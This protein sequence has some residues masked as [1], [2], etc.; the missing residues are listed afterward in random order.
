MFP[1][2][3]SALPLPPRPSLERYRKLAKDL[4]KACKEAGERD[5]ES[6]G[7]DPHPARSEEWAGQWAGQWAEDWID[8]LVRL[9][10]IALEPHLPVRVEQWIDEVAEFAQW[11]LKGD[12][13][14]GRACALTD[15][16]FV[17]ARSHGFESWPKFVHGVEALAHDGVSQ[18]SRFEAAADAIVAGDM[19]TLQRLLKDE[20]GLI[21]ARSMREHGASLLHYVAANG[22]E[23]YRQKTP[24]NIVEITELLLA[25]GADIEATAEVYAGSCKTLGLAATSGHPERGGDGGSAANAAAA[26]REDR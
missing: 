17:I 2:P 16:Q 7:A 1:N 25:A 13:A 6:S 24:K 8:A 11:Q 5:P 10:G 22:V 19:A 12:A 3:Q 18:A 23:G 4:V 20:P 21:H 14:G 9:S 26:W 15:A